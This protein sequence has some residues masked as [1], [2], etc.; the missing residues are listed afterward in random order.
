MISVCLIAGLGNRM[1]C[2]AFALGLK[3]KGYDIYV[4]EDSFTPRSTMTFEDV[5]MENIF[6][7]I[8]FKRTPKGS[9]P[10]CCVS[11]KKGGVLRRFSNLLLKEKYIKESSFEEIL[12]VESVISSSCCFIGQWQSEKYFEH[13]IDEVRRQFEF[14][15]FDEKK[16]I[17]MV[18]R[19]KSEE[20]VAIHIRKGKDYSI[21]FFSQTCPVDYYLK[22]ID[23]LK[24]NKK[25]PTFYVFTDNP[26]WAAKNLNDLEYTLVDWN[27]TCGSRN[28]RDMQLMSC[29][30]HNIIANS[31]YS[32]WGAYL[33][34]NPDKVVIA[35]AQWF[36]PERVEYKNNHIVPEN[37]IKF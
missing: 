25:N 3:E 15:P 1:F 14:I 35:P 10:F 36:S 16:N 8:S 2:Y 33:N 31:S 23:Y 4:D 13:A 29:A 20:S 11:G 30:K 19:M 22:S 5:K 17:E 9:F 21:P 26:E 32:W 27:P 7:N 28:F 6:P 24:R 34:P 18:N 12:D 37:W